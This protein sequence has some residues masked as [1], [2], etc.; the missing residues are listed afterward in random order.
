M[1]LEEMLKAVFDGTEVEVYALDE[2]GFRRISKPYD[3]SREL[4]ERYPQWQLWDEAALQI[5]RV[6]DILRTADG[7]EWMLIGGRPPHKPS[8][9]GRVFVEYMPEP[10]EE[11]GT[12]T[13]EFFPGVFDLK[14]RYIG[15][16]S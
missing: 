13:R 14:W 2:G 16:E 3:R 15:N 4:A 11:G 7:E 1:D 5:R 12:G 9:T 10:H 8:S 6:G